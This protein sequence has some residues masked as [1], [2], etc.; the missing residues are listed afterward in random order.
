MGNER[1][2]EQNSFLFGVRGNERRAAVPS[3]LILTNK[4]VLIDEVE[5]TSEETTRLFQSK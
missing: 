2:G 5:V 1:K 4:K 3:N